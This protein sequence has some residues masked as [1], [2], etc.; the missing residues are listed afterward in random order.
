MYIYIFKSTR[1]SKPLGSLEKRVSDFLRE[2]ARYFAACFCKLVKSP[3]PSQTYMY[4]P[5]SRTG[6][7]G[8][9]GACSLQLNWLKRSDS[10]KSNMSPFHDFPVQILTSNIKGTQWSLRLD[11]RPKM[12]NAQEHSK[13][14]VD[15]PVPSCSFKTPTCKGRGALPLKLAAI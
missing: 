8:F 15:L 6:A 11:F 10:L 13:R 2:I 3:G 5:L 9:A 7:G 14:A 1:K 4:G 12:D